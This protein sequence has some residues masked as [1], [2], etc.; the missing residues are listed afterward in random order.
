MP[1]GPKF[2]G[3]VV[4]CGW[5]GAERAVPRAPKSG[6]APRLL[7]FRGAGNCAASPDPPA[8]EIRPPN[9]RAPSHTKWKGARFTNNRGTQLWLWR[10]SLRPPHTALFGRA[11]TVPVTEFR[12]NRMLDAPDSSRALTICPSGIVTR[13]PAV[14]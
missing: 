13:V 1:A 7:S 9:N 3:P 2:Y 6:A 5:V 4:M 14:T 12:R 11:S 8:P 10:T